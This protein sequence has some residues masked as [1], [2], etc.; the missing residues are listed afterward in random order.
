MEISSQTVF[1]ILGS[2][3]F[4]IILC[5]LLRQ[6]TFIEN[7]K[8]VVLNNSNTNSNTTETTHTLVDMVETRPHTFAGILSASGMIVLKEL[9]VII[10]L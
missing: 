2:F 5:D 6:K 10:F 3:F 1:M 8:Y 4:Y 7:I 9:P